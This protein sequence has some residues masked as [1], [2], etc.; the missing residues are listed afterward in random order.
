M[1][2]FNHCAGFLATLILVAGCAGP[3]TTVE[4]TRHTQA[5]LAGRDTPERV[6]VV[7]P[8]DV[9]KLQQDVGG[10]GLGAAPDPAEFRTEVT[11]VFRFVRTNGKDGYVTATPTHYWITGRGSWPVS[12]TFAPF[13]EGLF[14]ERFPDKPHGLSA[15]NA[16]P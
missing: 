4:I 16:Q 6:A 2:W 13:V 8:G 3:V 7:R 14:Q 11:Y 1:P 12:S 9:S 15:I 5:S 10:L